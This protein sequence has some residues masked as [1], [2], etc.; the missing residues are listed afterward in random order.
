MVWIENGLALTREQ[1]EP[2]SSGE[3]EILVRRLRQNPNDEDARSR[4]IFSH[5]RL[6][7]GSAIKFARQSPNR[8]DDLFSAALLG[9]VTGVASFIKRPEIEGDQLTRFLASIIRRHV[10][11]EAFSTLVGAESTHRKNRTRVT[12]EEVTV[13]TASAYTEKSKI[14]PTMI[15]EVFDLVCLDAIDH[16]IMDCRMDGLS[17]T[18]TSILLS[19]NKN[20]VSS[21]FN[22]LDDRVRRTWNR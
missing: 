14:D 18:E 11:S 3:L 7:A 8:G 5:T 19:L 21:R 9:L 15:R 20:T 6:A 13:E 4:L 16:A 10:I 12:Y 17:Q 2:L 22:E 1:T